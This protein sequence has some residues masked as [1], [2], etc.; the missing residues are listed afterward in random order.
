MA[1]FRIIVAYVTRD[2]YEI[3]DP[4]V[5][6]AEQAEEAFENDEGKLVGGGDIYDE[7]I[8][9]VEEV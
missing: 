8:L 2:V 9:S 1:K 7:T 6:T 4:A 3:D 5:T